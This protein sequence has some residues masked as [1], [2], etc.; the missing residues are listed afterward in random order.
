MHILVPEI[1]DAGREMVYHPYVI[2]CCL[3]GC[4]GRNPHPS[5]SIRL[6]I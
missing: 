4:L 3:R 5:L 2:L 6:F 1:L